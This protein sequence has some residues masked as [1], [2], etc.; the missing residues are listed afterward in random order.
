[1]G[2]PRP[3]RDP[4][5]GELAANDNADDVPESLRPFIEA[6]AEAVYQDLQRHPPRPVA[7]ATPRK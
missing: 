1:V 2:D 3:R 5:D 4:P 6:M 7:V